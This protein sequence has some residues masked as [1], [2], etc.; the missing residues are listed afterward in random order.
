MLVAATK[1]NVSVPKQ[2][3]CNSLLPRL[4]NLEVPARDLGRTKKAWHFFSQMR[5]IAGIK[6]VKIPI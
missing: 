1:T 3:V 6:K 5:S 4:E 2:L